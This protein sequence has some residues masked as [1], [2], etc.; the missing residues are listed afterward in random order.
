MKPSNR[1][2]LVGIVIEAMLA[3]LCIFLVMQISTGEMTT[4]VSPEDAKS[5]ITAVLGGIMGGLGG[6]LLVIYIVLKRGEA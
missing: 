1:L 6:L 3:A 2:L 5:T 4:S